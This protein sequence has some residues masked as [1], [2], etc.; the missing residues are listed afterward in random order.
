MVGRSPYSEGVSAGPELRGYDER[1][2]AR[3]HYL[4]VAAAYLVGRQILHSLARTGYPHQVVGQSSGGL[5][6]CLDPAK[7]AA[8]PGQAEGR[9]AVEVLLSF[10]DEAVFSNQGLICV[11]GSRHSNQ[12]YFPSLPSLQL[13]A[14]GNDATVPEPQF[15][16]GLNRSERLDDMLL[17]CR[18]AHGVIRRWQACHGRPRAAQD[19]IAYWLQEFRHPVGMKLA[20]EIAHRFPIQE[21]RVEAYVDPLRP[22]ITVLAVELSLIEAHSGVTVH[23]SQE[24]TVASP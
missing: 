10:Q 3:D 11:L 5:V 19:E 15:R 7:F 4:F 2:G 24:G 8:I 14:A 21:Y 1:L 16:V 18:F 20:P 13:A 9:Y 23:L 22:G 12:V 6:D 17:V